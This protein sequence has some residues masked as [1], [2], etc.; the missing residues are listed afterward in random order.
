MGEVFSYVM[1]SMGAV[2]GVATLKS[3]S[4]K[5]EME[6]DGPAMGVILE[7]SSRASS[8]P[9]CGVSSDEIPPGKGPSMH[10]GTAKCPSEDAPDPRAW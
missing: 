4:V 7:L 3:V 5:N 9:Y 10:S 2:D 1:Y 6:R 8:T